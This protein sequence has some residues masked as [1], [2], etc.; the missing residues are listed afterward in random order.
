MSRHN[1]KIRQPSVPTSDNRLPTAHIQKIVSENDLGN[2]TNKEGYKQAYRNH[3]KFRTYSNWL[4]ATKVRDFSNCCKDAEEFADF[5]YFVIQNMIPQI[6]ENAFEIFVNCNPKNTPLFHSH[7]IDNEHIPL[8]QE[9]AYKLT[10]E[11]YDDPELSWWEIGGVQSVRMFGIYFDS[12]PGFYP[13][14]MDWHHLVYPDQNYNDKD[15]NNY[16][17]IPQKS[18]H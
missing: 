12:E 11:Q 17:Y 10:N 7:A 3:F 18:N 6:Y 13:V 16:N 8:V 5:V 9:I 1:K 2:R 4:D 14:F 15:Y